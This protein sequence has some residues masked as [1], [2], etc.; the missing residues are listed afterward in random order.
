M[1]NFAALAQFADDPVIQS[2]RRF[3]SP[4]YP[5]LALVSDEGN[6]ATWFF[7]CHLVTRV[8]TF[9]AL[10]LLAQAFGAVGWRLLAAAAVL[11]V[12]RGIYG[13]THMGGGGML[14]KYFTHSEL[15]TAFALLCIAA[16]LHGR[17]VLAAGLG[18]TAFATNAFIGLWVAVPLGLHALGLLVGSHAAG[19]VPATLPLRWRRVVLAALAFATPALPVAIWVAAAA[20]AGQADFDYPAF[21]RS[22][23]GKHFFLDESDSWSIVQGLASA[24][25]G[26]LAL[27]LVARRRAAGMV[28]A[29]LLLVLLLGM[30]VGA[31]SGSRL[32]LNLHLLRVDALVTM[33][34]AALVAVGAVRGIRAADPLGTALVLLAL[35]GLL[36][37]I[38][39]LPALALAMHALRSR[40]AGGWRRACGPAFL[41]AWLRAVAGHSRAAAAFSLVLLAAYASAGA[42]LARPRAAAAGGVPSAYSQLEGFWPAW[43]EWRE[44]QEWA[45]A[46]TP[47][48]ARFLVPT[49]LGGF[50]VGA[51]RA[52][53]VD[54]KE[55]ATVMWAPETHAEWRRRL[56]E[57]GRLQGAKEWMGYACANGLTFVVLDLRRAEL[58]SGQ[59]G[60][61][62][63][64]NRFFAVHRVENCD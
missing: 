51:Q 15:S 3:V 8:L 7:L 34:S 46:N 62:R 4:V 31:F 17:L 21:L 55:G 16:V 9:L 12:A 36:T 37:A 11:A 40:A 50:R 23:Y 26:V 22:Y 53:W 49:W 32:L 38:W 45:R 60:Q 30:L 6:I 59:E 63:F 52:A 27:R 61:P 57:V 19:P 64:E 18:G 48:E 20:S 58:A 13:A 42:Y 2:L 29:G 39:P 35:A 44:V 43:R 25:S 1:L 28:L 47:P 54:W 24:A 14:M 10:L 33:V 5:L 56:D 41:R